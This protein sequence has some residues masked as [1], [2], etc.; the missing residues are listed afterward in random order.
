MMNKKMNFTGIVLLMALFFSLALEAQELNTMAPDFTLKDLQGVD[1]KLSDQTGKVVFIFFFGYGCPHCH[2]NAENTEIEVYKYFSDRSDVVAI[3]IDSWDGSNSQVQDFK[4]QNDLSYKML[5]KGSAVTSVFKVSYD[6]LIVIDQ[7]GT[8]KYIS[9]GFATQEASKEARDVIYSL[10]SITPIIETKKEQ[11][12]ELLVYPNPAID[13]VTV[14]NP[15][16]SSEDV[17][18]EIIDITGKV[19]LEKASVFGLSKTTQLNLTDYSKGLYILRF[20]AGDK[21]KTIKLLVE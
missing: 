4:D 11:L 12:P 19:L 18:I 14:L 6:R 3:G 8:V 10:F 9:P 17:S 16:L 1:F 15:F 7:A 13:Y 20:K 2:A 5:V 21:H